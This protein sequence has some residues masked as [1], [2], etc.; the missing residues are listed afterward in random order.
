[1]NTNTARFAPTSSPRSN[2]AWPLNSTMMRPPHSPLQNH[3]L[4]ALPAE[5]FDRLSADLELVPLS[6]GEVLHEAA[7]RMQYVYFP[8]TAII[9]LVS[10][11]EDGATAETAIIGN[12]G[13][14]GMSLLIN[15]GTTP[16]RAV[17]QNAG[18]GYRSRCSY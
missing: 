2:I 6:V 3:L 10:V 9:S 15:G 8:T 12:E 11:L 16:N 13:V 1:M 14:L 5:D 7:G 18:F 4:A 17:V